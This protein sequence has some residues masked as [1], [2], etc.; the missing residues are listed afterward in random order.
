MKAFLKWLGRVIGTALCLVLVIVMLPYAS[1]WAAQIIPDLTGAA[2]TTSATLSRKLAQ[3]ARLECIQADREGVLESTVDAL[4]IGTVQSVQIAYDY[5]ASIGIDLSKVEIR[6]EGSRI[7]LA[8]PEMEVISDSL[9]P[10]Q[11]DRKDFWYPLTDERREKLL[12][13]EREACRAAELEA[14]KTDEGWA[15]V[16]AALENTISGWIGAESPRLTIQY[17]HP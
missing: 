7:T 5:H 1:R 10:T 4:L 11:I 15:Y 2:M 13:D 12:Q 6:V 14:A 17:E 3:S 8:L 16:T 9:T